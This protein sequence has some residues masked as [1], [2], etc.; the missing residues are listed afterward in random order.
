MP[1]CQFIKHKKE[2]YHF[3][4]KQEKKNKGAPQYFQ[5]NTLFCQ[6]AFVF[7][8]TTLFLNR[9]CAIQNTLK[10]QAKTHLITSFF[11]EQL[12]VVACGVIHNLY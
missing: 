6:C 5:E 3:S 2:R 12:P 1:A 10:S 8:R 9:C 7:N 4:R 11:T